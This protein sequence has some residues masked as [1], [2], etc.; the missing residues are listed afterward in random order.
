MLFPLNLD[1]IR[2]FNGKYLVESLLF[3]RKLCD[4]ISQKKVEILT[5]F[6]LFRP[7]CSLLDIP[8]Q[9]ADVPDGA[10]IPEP[11]PLRR[12]LDT[13]GLFD[14]HDQADTV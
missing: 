11:Q 4:I 12:D 1:F 6:R 7:K 13:E 5:N 3:S 9:A 10:D 2:S 8:D 14:R